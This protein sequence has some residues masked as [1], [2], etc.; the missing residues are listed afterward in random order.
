MPSLHLSTLSSA[1]IKY[2]DLTE[3]MEFQRKPRKEATN[4]LW[5]YRKGG[6]I[7]S[8][9]A[10][11]YVL[12]IQGDSDH[13]G[14]KIIL[15]QKKPTEN[16][17]QKWV[18]VTAATGQEVVFDTSPSMPPFFEADDPEESHLEQVDFRNNMHPD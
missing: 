5:F 14:T 6:F 2:L 4:Q 1:S 13:T 12:D 7:R 8:A 9:M 10:R 3:T 17:N 18:F 11:N 16:L 15:F